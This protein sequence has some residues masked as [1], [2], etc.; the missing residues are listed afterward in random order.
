MAVKTFRRPERAGIPR[1]G[2]L[3]LVD[4]RELGPLSTTP[5]ES[6]SPAACFAPRHRSVSSVVALAS[7]VYPGST[8]GSRG[9]SALG[10]F[11]L[12]VAV[13]PVGDRRHVLVPF[14]P[15]VP[16][17]F[18]D[19]QLGLDARGLELVEDQLGLLDRD[20]EILVAVDDQRGRVVGRDVSDRG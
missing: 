17:A 9:D 1:L 20:Q 14:R 19:D 10:R 5:L 18:L 13:E 7:A 2:P 8:Y 11:R 12:Q 3:D 16:R 6:P 4:D 15:A